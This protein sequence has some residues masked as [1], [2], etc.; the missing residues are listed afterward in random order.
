[1]VTK[2]LKAIKANEGGRDPQE[3]I[4]LLAPWDQLVLGDS[5]GGIVCA[6]LLAPL[7]L[8]V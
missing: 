8:Q 7:L 2:G 1:M 4:G 5:L 6:P 3:K